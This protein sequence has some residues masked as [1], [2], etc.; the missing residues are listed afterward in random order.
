MV[1]DVPIHLD[2]EASWWYDA[3]SE[4]VKANWALLTKELL[5]EFQEKESYQ[6]F[7]RST[8]L[9]EAEN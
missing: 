3:Q 8:Q 4:E 2:D 7:V 1:G 6:A 9:D 5:N